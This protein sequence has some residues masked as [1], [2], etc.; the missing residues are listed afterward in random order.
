MLEEHEGTISM[1]IARRTITNLQFADYIDGLA[2][3]AQLVERIDQTSKAYG[4]KTN[5]EKNKTND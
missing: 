4:M 5:A 2:K 1:S 3:L